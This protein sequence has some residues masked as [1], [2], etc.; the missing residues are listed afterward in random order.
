[1]RPPIT[2]VLGNTAFVCRPTYAALVAAEAEIGSLF[3]LVERASTGSMMLSEMVA[4]I[5][6]CR[7]DASQDLSR[8]GFEQRCVEAGLAHV[9]P[10]FRQLMEQAL[11]GQ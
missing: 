8:A 1:M 9:T 5:W 10:L 7:A 6:H 11:G 3:A 4:L 2:T